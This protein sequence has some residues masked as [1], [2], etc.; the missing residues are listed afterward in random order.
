VYDSYDQYFPFAIET[1]KLPSACAC[2]SGAF[3]E[4]H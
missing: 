1:F 3:A 2:H 4:V